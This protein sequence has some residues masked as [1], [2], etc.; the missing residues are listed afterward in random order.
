[1]DA[2]RHPEPCW[3]AVPEG[4]DVHRRVVGP[5]HLQIIYNTIQARH[6]RSTCCENG[7]GKKRGQT[8][9]NGSDQAGGFHPAQST[10]TGHRLR[11]IATSGS[12]WSEAARSSGGR[13]QTEWKST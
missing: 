10:A 5:L 9:R 3:D 13:A 2:W 7:G 11:L 8:E 4:D 6:R 1:M 12:P